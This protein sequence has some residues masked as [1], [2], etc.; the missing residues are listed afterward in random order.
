MIGPKKLKTIREE[1]T[2]AV[3]SNKADPIQAL[4]DLISTRRSHTGKPESEE[5]LQSLRRFLAAKGS[6]RRSSRKTKLASGSR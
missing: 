5:V 4:G 6:R 3:A 2:R 1:L